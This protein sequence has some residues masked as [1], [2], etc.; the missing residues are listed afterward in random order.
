[1]M[2][3]ELLMSPN[4]LVTFLQKPAA[5]FTKADI[6]NYIQQNEIRMVNFMYP[7]ADGRLKTLNFVINNASYLD[8]ILTCG[9][10]VDGSSL[11][12][13]IEAGS[14]DLYVIPR[15]RTAFVDPFAEIPTLVM[16]CSFFNKDGEPLESSP[17]Y[18]LHKACK[19][20]TDVTGMEFQ[21]MGELEYYVISEDDGLFPA[22]DQR[23]YHESGPYAKFNDFR[24]QCMSYIAQTGGQIKYGHSEVG[25]FMLDGKVYEQNEI[26][27]LPVNAENAADQLM[28]AKWVIRNLAYQY[29]YDITFAPKITVG[30]AGSGLHIHMRMM[31]DGQ[32][33]ML[34]DGVLS[35]TARKAIAG[36]MQLAPSITAFGNT[37]PTSYFRLVPHQE[38][39]TNVCWGDRNRSVLVRVPL[40]WSA[41]TDMC[42]L[43]NPLES[44]SNYDTTQKQTVEMRSPDGSADL[45]Q[46]LAG[47]A[48]ACRHGFEIEN[49]LAIAEQTYF[50]VNIHQK[51][52]ADNLKALAQLPDSCAASA[53]CLQKQRTVFEQYNVF[54]P[55]MINGIISRLRSYNDATLR[56]DIQ[57]KPEE[58][59]ALVSKFF[60]CG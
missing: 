8:A 26:E 43:A 32:N 52:N 47:L 51:E 7:A 12:P 59:L 57:D 29:G 15:F 49:A 10:R 6:I 16:L 17:E 20:F 45:Y 44:D 56:K 27:F 28:I 53:D 33:Q 13:F 21:A 34:K 40:G 11:F 37:N 31:K 5:E 60:H 3:Q 50:N 24:T 42:A 39:P 30:K 2:N 55:A 36:M 23:G 38:A 25:N 9:E 18:T 46:L 48:V 19:A 1:M 22:T 4:R 58:M 14:S 35:D 54:S 41:Q